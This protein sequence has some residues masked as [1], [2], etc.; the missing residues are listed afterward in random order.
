MPRQKPTDKMRSVQVREFDLDRL[1]TYKIHPRET[2]WEVIKKI[3]DEKEEV[4]KQ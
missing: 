3:I 4:K 1:S 2:Y